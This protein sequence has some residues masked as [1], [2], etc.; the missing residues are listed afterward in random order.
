MLTLYLFKDATF[1]ETSL[2]STTSAK[3]Q[4]TVYKPLGWEVLCV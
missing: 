1:L 2:K 3:Q 4:G